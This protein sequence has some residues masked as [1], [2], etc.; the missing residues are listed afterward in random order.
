MNAAIDLSSL[1]L[2]YNENRFIDAYE[3]IL[4]RWPKSP[5]HWPELDVA[6]LCHGARL[7]QRLGSAKLC[8]HLYDLAWAR[9]PQHPL[10]RIFARFTWRRPFDLTR[11]VED[12]ATAPEIATEDE[13]LRADWY[14]SNAHLFAIMRDFSQARKLLVRA[15]EHA[16]TD[17]AWLECV[18]AEIALADDDWKVALEAAE[19]AWN[20]SPGKPAAASVLARSLTQLERLP[21]VAER[22]LGVAKSG[23]SYEVYMMGLWYLA[24]R[25]ERESTVERRELARQAYTSM[26]ATEALAPLADLRTQRA[27]TFARMD[28]AMLMGDHELFEGHARSLPLPWI[29][30]ALA[31]KSRKVEGVQR[32]V[33]YR[34]ARQRHLGCLPA[35]MAAVLGAF[36]NH[37][38]VEKLTASLSYGGTPTWRAIRWLRESGYTVRAF[39]VTP[40]LAR[41]LLDNGIPFIFFFAAMGSNHATAAIGYHEAT[42]TLTIHDPQSTRWLQLLMKNMGDDEAPFGPEGLAF[43]PA[44]RRDDLL[45]LVPQHASQPAMALLGFHEL[46]GESGVEAAA[47]VVE[48]LSKSWPD[49]PMTVRLQSLL[50]ARNG[51]VFKAIEQHEE[52]LSEF[53]NC[54]Q[55]RRE[56]LSHLYATGNTAQIGKILEDVV[57]R[58]HLP[59]ISGSQPWRYPPATFITRYADYLGLSAE[60]SLRATGLLRELIRREPVEAEAYHVLGDV[61]WRHGKV[62]EAEY[63]FHVAAC[64]HDID[65][66]YARTLADIMRYQG[67][68][69]EALSWLEARVD[70]LGAGVGGASAWITWIAALLAYGHPER[71]IIAA[72]RAEATC[73][74]DPELARWTT[75][76]WLRFARPDRA[77]A[78]LDTVE[79]AGSPS[80]FYSAAT[81]FYWAVGQWERALELAASWQAEEPDDPDVCRR[82]ITLMARRV[83]RR[84]TADMA[85]E[86][87]RSHEGNDSFEELWYE[88]LQSHGRDDEARA[89]LD[90]R[91]KRNPRDVWA[92][93]EKAFTLLDD[94]RH[95]GRESACIAP[96]VTVVERATVLAPDDPRTLAL[97][98]HVAELQKRRAEAIDLFFRAITREPTY[99]HAYGQLWSLHEDS[100][101]DEHHRFIDRMAAVLL[102]NDAALGQAR[103]LAFAVAERYGYDRAAELVEQWRDKRSDSWE[104]LETMAHLQIFYGQGRKAATRARELLEPAVV[105]Y[106]DNE[107]LRFSLADAYLALGEHELVQSCLGD[108]LDRAPT[109]TG[110]RQRLARTLLDTG[111]VERA[112]KLLV[113]GTLV[114]PLDESCW[115]SLAQL[116]WQTG[117]RGMAIK[118]LLQ[119]LETMP[120]SIELRQLV[121]EWLAVVGDHEYAVEMAREGLAVYPDG[122]YL[123]YLL[124]ESLL[125]SDVHTDVREIEHALRRSLELD[126]TLFAAADALARLLAQQSRLDEARTV[127]LEIA[128]DMQDP[129]P[130]LVRAAWVTRVAG[131]HR[132]AIAEMVSALQRSPLTAWGWLNLLDWLEADEEWERARELLANVPLPLLEDPAFASRRLGLL[133][134]AGTPADELDAIWQELLENFP[135]H[136]NLHLRRFD[137]LVEAEDWERATRLLEQ[138]LLHVHFSPF[139]MARLCHLRVHQ[140]RH[141]EALDIALELWST[142]ADD[143]KWPANEAFRRLDEAGLAC[144]AI[145]ESLAVLHAGKRLCLPAICNCAAGLY[146]LETGEVAEHWPPRLNEEQARATNGQLLELIEAIHGAPWDN[147]TAAGELL[148]YFISYGGRDEFYVFFQRHRDECRDSLE[149]WMKVGHLLSTWN[150]LTTAH[151]WLADWRKVRGVEPWGVSAYVDALRERGDLEELHRTSRDVIEMLT[152]DQGAQYYVAVHAET[153]LRL[154]RDDAFCQWVDQWRSLLEERSPEFEVEEAYIWLPNVVL[155]FRELLDCSTADC[156]LQLS[157]QLPLCFD[158]HTAS[159]V[160]DEWCERLKRVVP[161]DRVEMVRRRLT[162]GLAQVQAS[163]APVDGGVT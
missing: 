107:T 2:H 82:Y 4:P 132:E 44:S 38:D 142:C 62:R 58:K 70:R 19:R 75:H 53:P 6:L 10:V 52:L 95:A 54:I 87:W 85:E 119:A 120:E 139:V 76:F 93:H 1:L 8:H 64:L 128:K 18:E 131:R 48:R 15:R 50:A 106:P 99:S 133:E 152:H 113:E 105:R 138:L 7:A 77:Q 98:A 47:Q 126:V 43:V 116:R 147:G 36:E 157:E 21:E 129:G 65:D 150:D 79:Q 124:G 91:L 33:S 86:W 30:R 57:E 101:E 16:V 51:K 24:A 151:R 29:K 55:L 40:K 27:L 143:E 61:L 145:K 67:R 46:L 144:R 49:H 134:A 3:Y 123:W 84:R 66:H 31:D 92:C 9:D 117:G 13:Q 78:A 127:V 20:I 41:A 71:A 148:E 11:V 97:R 140:G 25:A 146:R 56:L 110:V 112:E 32:L 156:A 88:T 130:A 141:D 163:E 118:T 72:E 89:L 154:G 39:V 102:G 109:N 60:G 94:V 104:L 114:D 111:A 161:A 42:G 73:S 37:V 136:E 63:A 125:S 162:T 90:D 158:A 14:A 122:A 103:N 96:L 155:A 12:F 135:T 74:G 100:A 35:S 121:I 159:W 80:Q 153:C 17:R 137:R 26:S 160:V 59:A 83:G 68:E 81:A 28:F 22:L 115:L 69:A 149:L 34:P 45:R 23:Q 108:L 5:Q